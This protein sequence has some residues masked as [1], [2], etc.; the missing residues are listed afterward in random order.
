MPNGN[1]R[2]NEDLSTVSEKVARVFGVAF[3]LIGLFLII[4]LV[5]G[6]VISKLPYRVDPNLPIPTLRDSEEFTNQDSITLSGTVLPG[7][8]VALYIDENRVKETITTDEDGSFSFEDISIDEEGDLSFEAAVVR[9]GLFKRRS[10][11]SNL[12]ETTVD[13]TPPS[14]SISLEYDTE[15]GSETTTVRGSAEPNSIVVLDGDTESYE[16]AVDPD[17]NFEMTDLTLLDGTNVFS[18]RIKD[19]AGN[20]VLASDTVEIVYLASADVLGEVNGDGVSIGPNGGKLP[21]SA[22]E[23]EA[24]LEFLAGNKLMFIMSLVALFTFAGSSTLA[25]RHARKEA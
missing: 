18:V 4:Y 23:L 15:S 20:E 3:I 8:K 12:V 22:G 5:G 6:F 13:W 11:M 21:E 24:A 14:T 17:G 25:V 10:E 2:S 7:E 16:I 1:T 9:G 19:R